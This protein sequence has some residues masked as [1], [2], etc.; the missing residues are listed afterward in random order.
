MNQTQ[1]HDFVSLSDRWKNK[2][3]LT[4]LEESRRFE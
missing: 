3:I 2:D 1:D 4:G